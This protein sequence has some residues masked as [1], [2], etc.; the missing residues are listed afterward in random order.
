M[1]SAGRK[2]L[3]FVIV[4]L[5]LV[6]L[7]FI[8]VFRHNKPAD[9]SNK[10]VK[11]NIST[12]DTFNYSKV[13][14]VEDQIK[15]LEDRE[16][17]GNFD[18]SSKMTKAQYQKIFRTSVIVGDSITEGLTSYGFLSED[19]VFSKIG[20]SVLNSDDIINTAAKTY[21]GFA[22]FSFGM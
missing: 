19:Q 1:T 9:Y 6:S 16:S 7:F 22:F 20:A 11:V 3:I 15:L 10:N 14:T 17:K 5:I 13:V 18:V 8:N 12:I 2:Y 21:P 4:L